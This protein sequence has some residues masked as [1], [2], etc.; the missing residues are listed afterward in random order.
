MWYV[1]TRVVNFHAEL[2]LHYTYPSNVYI[3]D[4]PEPVCH[5][6]AEVFKQLFEGM[7]EHLYWLPTCDCDGLFKP[8]QCD[9]DRMNPGH[10]ECWCSYSNSISEVVGTR[11]KIIDICTDPTTL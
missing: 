5:T 9:R 1:Y 4:Q 8:I 10:L 2:H 3:V 11:Q 7:P 6:Q